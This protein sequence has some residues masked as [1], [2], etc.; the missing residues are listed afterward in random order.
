MTRRALFCPSCGAVFDEM[1]VEFGI[2]SQSGRCASCGKRM[3]A[4]ESLGASPASSDVYAGSQQSMLSSL[5]TAVGGKTTLIAAICVV[6][7]F[8]GGSS[9]HPRQVCSAPESVRFGQR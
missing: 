4:E 8:V 6:V 1:S 7:L 3:D 2:V 5:R 9:P